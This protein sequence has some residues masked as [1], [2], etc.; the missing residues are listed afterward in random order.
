MFP[1]SFRCGWWCFPCSS[2]GWC[3]LAP[4]LLGG[5]WVPFGCFLLHLFVWG[6]RVHPLFVCSY[7]LHFSCFFF[8]C[9]RFSFYFLSVHFNILFQLL[10][11]FFLSLY[12]S[13]SVVFVLRFLFF[14]VPFLNFSSS[15]FPFTCCGTTARVQAGGAFL[16]PPFE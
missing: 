2:C 3:R 9:L 13:F 7:D 15:H 11:C 10:Q 1:C 6:G 5:A 16:P 14:S 12:S 8:F 4:P